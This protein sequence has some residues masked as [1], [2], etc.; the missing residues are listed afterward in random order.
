MGASAARRGLIVRAESAHA[1]FRPSSQSHPIER[2]GHQASP[3]WGVIVAAPARRASRTRATRRC[4]VI[5]SSRLRVL[6]A[7]MAA[8]S[9]PVTKGRADLHVPR[10]SPGAGGRDR[11]STRRTRTGAILTFHQRS[12]G[13]AN[14]ASDTHNCLKVAILVRTASSRSRWLSRARRSTSGRRNPDRLAEERSGE[15]WK[16]AESGEQF[17]VDV[18]LGSAKP[19]DFDA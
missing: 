10:A 14:M 13:E 2:A 7:Q 3:A 15:A 1:A 8:A 5:S 18:P 6:R 16:F 11:A 19:E 4:L 12:N 9:P 17:P